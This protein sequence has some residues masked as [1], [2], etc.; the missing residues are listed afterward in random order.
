MDASAVGFLIVGVVGVVA[1]AGLLVR[2][3]RL[4]ERFFEFK[5]HYNVTAVKLLNVTEERDRLASENAAFRLS[6]ETNSIAEKAESYLRYREDLCERYSNEQDLERKMRLRVHLDE[7]LSLED[8]IGV[9]NQRQQAAIWTSLSVREPRE[10]SELEVSTL[11]RGRRT[12]YSTMF[13]P[14]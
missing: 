5:E 9:S 2:I 8:R 6:V 11:I 13:N 3:N 7:L 10:A 4:D 14:R 12:L 1:I